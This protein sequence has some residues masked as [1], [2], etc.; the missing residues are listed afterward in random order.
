MSNFFEPP[1]N[2]T[3]SPDEN[4]IL[5][6]HNNANYVTYT[7]DIYTT[8]YNNLYNIYNSCIDKKNFIL[9]YISSITKNDNLL[10]I[11]I[12]FSVLNNEFMFKDQIFRFCEVN[13]NAGII[14]YFNLKY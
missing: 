10:H 14:S 7:L 12:V 9:R 13:K 6:T 5:S 8:N 4:Y 1:P 11:N 3:N 2:Y